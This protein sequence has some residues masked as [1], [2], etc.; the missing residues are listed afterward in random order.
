MKNELG[1]VVLRCPIGDHEV[2]IR[3]MP[4]FGAPLT[5][6][7]QPPVQ[8]HRC[9]QHGTD[10]V[11]EDDDSKLGA[12]AYWLSQSG[13]VLFSGNV[14]GSALAAVGDESGN[15]PL[16]LAAGANRL[17][18]ARNARRF[19]TRVAAPIAPSCNMSLLR[20]V[21]FSWRWAV[22][23]D[24]RA[25]HLLLTWHDGVF[26]GAARGL[27]DE[28]LVAKTARAASQARRDGFAYE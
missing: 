4:T 21:G 2:L 10:L 1:Y 6:P 3:R 19:A 11:A 9:E 22:P 27:P 16:F 5:S 23:E 12:E 24:G 25:D 28:A 17:E 8:P 26:L 7:W 14:D 15:T 13:F 20:D 18:A